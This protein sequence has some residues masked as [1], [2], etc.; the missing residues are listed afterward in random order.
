MHACMHTHLHV[1]THTRM[2]ANTHTHTHTH[3]HTHRAT[4]V[5]HLNIPDVNTLIEGAT[6]QKLA[7]GTEGHTVHWLLVLGQRVKTRPPIHL[8]Q[9][10]RRVKR[11]AETQNSNVS[12]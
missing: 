12:V 7:I 4:S 10:H 9:S 3:I 8:P 1:H 6:G 5:T 11:R 2:H